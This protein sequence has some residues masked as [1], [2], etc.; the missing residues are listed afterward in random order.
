M[1]NRTKNDLS[2]NTVKLDYQALLYMAKVATGKC[3]ETIGKQT[4][5]IRSAIDLAE[6]T[7]LS[8]Q[9]LWISDEANNLAICAD[10][11]AALL[12]GIDR[13]NVEIV[14]HIPK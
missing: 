14:N 9:A 4:D 5:K 10:T 1:N 7:Q 8:L 6:V 2:A 3:L 12:G 13:E 11:L